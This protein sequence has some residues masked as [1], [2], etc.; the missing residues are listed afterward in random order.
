LIQTAYQVIF[1]FEIATQTRQRGSADLSVLP[2]PL[3]AVE[4]NLSAFPVNFAINAMNSLR[5]YQYLLSNSKKKKGASLSYAAVF[6]FWLSRWSQKQMHAIL[7]LN[8]NDLVFHLAFFRLAEFR[9][10]RFLLLK[11]CVTSSTVGYV[12]IHAFI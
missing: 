3:P 10:I 5:I 12:S 11:W 7:V 8:C 9:T 1:Q 2:A 6:F 4:S